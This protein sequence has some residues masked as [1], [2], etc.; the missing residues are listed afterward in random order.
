M[1]GGALGGIVGY[2]VADTSGI[3]RFVVDHSLVVATAVY[4]PVSQPQHIGRVRYCQRT[5]RSRTNAQI[6]P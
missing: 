5:S 2:M 4:W 6:M 3:L 1:T